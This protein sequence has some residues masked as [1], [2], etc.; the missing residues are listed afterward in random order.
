M[1]KSASSSEMA[2]KAENGGVKEKPKAAAISANGMAW[3]AI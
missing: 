2:A 1:A 3:M